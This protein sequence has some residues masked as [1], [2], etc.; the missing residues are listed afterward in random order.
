MKVIIWPGAYDL[1]ARRDLNKARLER[2]LFPKR[3]RINW[4]YVVV[5][6]KHHMRTLAAA[7]MPDN[8]G[9]AW[10]LVDSGFEPNAANVLG[11]AFRCTGDVRCKRRISG[12]R[13]DAQKAEQ[14]LQRHVEIGIDMGKNRIKVRHQRLPGSWRTADGGQIAHRSRRCCVQMS[15]NSSTSPCPDR[16]SLTLLWPAAMD[17]CEWQP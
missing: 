15:A 3:E 1:P 12:D 11:N 5:A 16:R 7:L 6:I 4:L 17:E 8:N 9:M 10:C 2:R 13:G 14:P